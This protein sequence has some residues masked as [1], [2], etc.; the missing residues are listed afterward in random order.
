MKKKSISLI[1]EL[2]E[3]QIK[4][5]REMEKGARKSHFLY[6]GGRVGATYTSLLILHY[7][8]IKYSKKF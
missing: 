5:A 6:W 1:F 8:L 7:L 3:A 4:D 2:Q